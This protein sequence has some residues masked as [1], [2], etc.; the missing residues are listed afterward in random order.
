MSAEVVAVIGDDWV[1]ELVAT[2]SRDSGWEVERVPLFPSE[3]S[4]CPPGLADESPQF[5]DRASMVLVATPASA[6]PALSVLL[7]G[8]LRREAVV[9]L[10]PGQ[11]GGALQLAAAL[12]SGGDGPVVA[13]TSWSP[14]IRVAGDLVEPG[15]VPLASVP[16]SAAAEVTARVDPLFAA[17]PVESPLWT[18]LLCPDYVLRTV[19]TLLS[20]AATSGTT[21]RS[22][23]SG[24]GEG[25][26]TGLEDE[27]QAIAAALGLEVPRLGAWL[28]GVF[29]TPST[30]LGD[31][32]GPLADLRVADLH[33]PYGLGDLAPFGLAPLVSIG[34]ALGIE[35]PCAAGM[36]T[37]AGHLLGN[38]FR[39]GGRGV[40][41]MGLADALA[42]AAARADGWQTRGPKLEG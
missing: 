4:G 3:R 1:A 13:E 41:T 23:L 30:T 27:R 32:L 28:S 9:V 42:S 14:W 36:L 35:T 17:Q 11:V 33:D 6:H 15:P 31:A 16:E 7:T 20:A 2:R 21:L 39:L 37:I 34:A 8:C 12:G 24:P 5:L 18:S 38:D 40:M 10:L 26:A 19:P 25:L 22:A 29:G